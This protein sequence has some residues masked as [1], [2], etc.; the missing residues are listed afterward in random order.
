LVMQT[1]LVITREVEAMNSEQPGPEGVLSELRRFRDEAR[2]RR[3]AYWFPLI[4]FGLTVCAC[5]AT[6]INIPI[7]PDLLACNRGGI[8]CEIWI[9]AGPWTQGLAWACLLLA[10]VLATALWYRWHAHVTGI[11]TRVRASVLVW[12][13]AIVVGIGV[14]LAAVASVA[15]VPLDLRQGTGPMLAVAAGFAVLTWLERSRLL[16]FVTV[17]YTLL[18]LPSMHDGSVREANQ[19]LNGIWTDNNSLGPGPMSNPTGDLDEVVHQRHRLGILTI[20]AEAAEVEFGFLQQT[21][22]LTA[23]NLSR[24]LTV[25]EE[26]GLVKIRKGYV[27]RR[28]KTWVR[29][30][31]AGTT[32]LTRELSALQDLVT[33][34]KAPSKADSS[35]R[36]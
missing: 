16:L 26:A 1:T 31:R 11:G 30:T 22:E 27:G 20:A 14:T 28:P 3:H 12:V 13:A 29:I 18:V 15:E 32:A 35:R 36:E 6:Y 24:H 19:L 17:A 9:N 2:T 10:A 23:G 25:L 33:R 21:L 34:L 4:I 5:S 7:S 8:E